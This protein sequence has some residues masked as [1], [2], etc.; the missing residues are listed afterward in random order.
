M[1]EVPEEAVREQERRVGKIGS[2]MEQDVREV[3]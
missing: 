1:E 3:L 2:H